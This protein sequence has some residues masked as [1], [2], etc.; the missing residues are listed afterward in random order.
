MKK[1]TSVASNPTRPRR[2][3]SNARRSEDI[4][5]QTNVPEVLPRA[6]ESAAEV[7]IARIAADAD[8]DRLRELRPVIWATAL[9]QAIPAII[10]VAFA[11]VSVGALL[12]GNTTMFQRAVALTLTAIAPAPVVGALTGKPRLDDREAR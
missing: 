3:A 8:R 4:A 12:Q 5:I 9:R 2:T 1:L 10:A 6:F 7:Q 11:A